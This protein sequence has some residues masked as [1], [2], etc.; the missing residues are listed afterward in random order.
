MYSKAFFTD[1]RR[2]SS[3]SHFSTFPSLKHTVCLLQR[4]L[5]SDSDTFSSAL[6]LHSIIKHCSKVKS[7]TS[8]FKVVSG[9]SDVRTEQGSTP[10]SAR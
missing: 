9:S 5:C 3:S 1:F 4:P 10:F 6:A 8:S 2:L 7:L